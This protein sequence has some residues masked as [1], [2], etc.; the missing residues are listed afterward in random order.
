MMFLIS[1]MAITIV[2]LVAAFI[3]T[4]SYFM[5]K[6]EEVAGVMLSN[7][8]AI[9]TEEELNS[10]VLQR[11]EF[12]TEELLQSIRS[13]MENGVGTLNILRQLY[14]EQTVLAW[15]GQY[16]FIEKNDSLPVNMYKDDAF[17]MDEKGIMTYN[18]GE[19]ISKK[20]IDVSKYQ[21]KIDWS[22][23]KGDGIEYAFIRMG[24]RGY[25]ESGKLVTD[26]T[27][28]QN[29]NGALKNDIA[30]GIYFLSQAVTEEEAIEEANYVIEAIEG[31]DV[32]YPVVI[33][34]EEITTDKARTDDLTKEQW[35]A[36][37][38]AFCETIKSA[39]YTPMIYGNLVTYFMLLDMDKLAEYDKW[40]ANYSTPVYFPYEFKVW[41]YTDQGSVSGIASDVDL[42]VSFID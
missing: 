22:Q 38:I 26:E 24:Y 15:K 36:N 30:V 17:L 10:L 35:T 25:G 29:V 12:V 9:Y 28:E 13:Q 40:V 1:I 33:D 39:G 3:V 8:E 18:D 34:I 31:Y 7:G 2:F 5:S 20:G 32:T 23:V 6:P 11:E 41:Q 14:P 4:V 42:N 16:H 21:G 19:I 27:F 37:C